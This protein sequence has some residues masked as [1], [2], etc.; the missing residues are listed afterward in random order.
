MEISKESEY[1]KLSLDWREMSA[2]QNGQTL[3]E[4]GA[5]FH[6]S[7]VEVL[8]LGAID[9]EDNEGDRYSDDRLERGSLAPLRA[10]L[11]EAGDLRVFVPAAKLTDVRIT[12]AELARSQ[13]EFMGSEEAREFMISLLP[14]KGIVL[15]FGGSMRIID[16]M[17]EAYSADN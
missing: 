1:L 13:V 2:L 12:G 15:A 10:H 7:K 6:D 3:G 4:R 8:P 11:D 16:V 9:P 14:E 17:S 5:I